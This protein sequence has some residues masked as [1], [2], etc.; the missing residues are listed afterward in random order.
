MYKIVP[1]TRSQH[2]FLRSPKLPTMRSFNALFTLVALVSSTFVLATEPTPTWRR[3]LSIDGDWDSQDIAVPFTR[4]EPISNKRGPEPA[5]TNAQRLARGLKL[6][7]PKRR[8]GGAA[9]ARRSAGPFI[10]NTGT[11]LITDANTN[12]ILG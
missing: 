2:P 9:L 5:L 12:A 7:P 8:R 1:L 6:L 4:A 11:I 10:T 3:D